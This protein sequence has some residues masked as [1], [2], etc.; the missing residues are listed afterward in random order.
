MLRER[1]KKNTF[2]KKDVQLLSQMWALIHE[3]NS[4]VAMWAADGEEQTRRG[5]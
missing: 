5:G 3:F 2:S 4:N 1:E